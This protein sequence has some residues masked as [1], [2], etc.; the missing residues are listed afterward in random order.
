[1]V[2]VAM[3]WLQ[4]LSIVCSVYSGIQEF[5][6]L[7]QVEI[8]EVLHKWFK[9]ASFNGYKNSVVLCNWKAVR[10]IHSTITS[11][12]YD[13]VTKII[14]GHRKFIPHDWYRLFMCIYVINMNKRSVSRSMCVLPRARS[15]Y[16]P[17]VCICK[18]E[19]YI[20]TNQECILSMN[21]Y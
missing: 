5:E 10:R 11:Y 16:L 2:Q 21:V 6:E 19:V 12:N 8:V 13:T 18:T 14:E 15:A 20:R 9:F 1:M 17:G 3:L 7:L 4:L